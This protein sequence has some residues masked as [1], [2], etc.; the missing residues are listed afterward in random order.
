MSECC[1]KNYIFDRQSSFDGG[2]YTGICFK[3]MIL[4]DGEN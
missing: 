2:E 3:N 4:L 1:A